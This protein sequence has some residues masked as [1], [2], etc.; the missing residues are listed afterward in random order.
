MIFPAIHLGQV[1]AA[2]KDPDD[3]TYAVIML[4]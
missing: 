1:I 3:L 2:G 4:R